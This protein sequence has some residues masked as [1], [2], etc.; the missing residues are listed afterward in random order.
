[1]R[2]IDPEH[3]H[4]LLGPV[5]KDALELLPELAPVIGFEVERID[6]LVLLRRILSVLNRAVRTVLE[7]LRVFLHV[8]V[9]RRALE[10]DVECDIHPQ[11]PGR[12]DKLSEVIERPQ[13]RMAGLVATLFRSDCPRAARLSRL[14]RH[15]VVFALAEGVADRVDRGKIDNVETHLLD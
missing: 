15:R 1:M 13:F 14:R 3:P 11:A 5:G 6:I 9:I 8:R 10:R 7:P 12:L 2:I 4:A